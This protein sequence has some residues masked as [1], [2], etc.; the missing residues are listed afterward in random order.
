MSES[1][2]KETET[3]SSTANTT[4]LK[5]S[6]S[7]SEEKC[8]VSPQETSDV[9]GKSEVGPGAEGLKSVPVPEGVA[10]GTTATTDEEE[11]GFVGIGARRK[12]KRPNQQETQGKDVGALKQLQ[13]FQKLYDSKGCCHCFKEKL[14]TDEVSRLPRCKSCQMP[15]YCSRKCQ[16]ADWKK[17]HKLHCKEITAIKSSI[18]EQEYK[19]IFVT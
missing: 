16:S 18:R 4:K 10:S 1:N 11:K 6:I 5:H 3:D 8:Q 2:N 12:E 13:E 14:E 7:S 9:Q 17:R 15:R 19:E